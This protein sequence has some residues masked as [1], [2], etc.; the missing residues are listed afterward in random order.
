MQ[1]QGPG[2]WITH[3][4][5]DL[6]SSRQICDLENTSIQWALPWPRDDGDGRYDLESSNLRP[7]SGH[8]PA[9]MVTRD[10]RHR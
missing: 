9:M 2:H 1:R 3:S 5:Y 8:Y 10:G 6:E 7:S 4:R